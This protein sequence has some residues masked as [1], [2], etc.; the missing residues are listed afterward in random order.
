MFSWQRILTKIKNTM[1]HR[2]I[3]EK[4]FNV[5]LEDY[6]KSVL[7]TIVNSWDQMSPEE[8]TS[9]STLN[10]FFCGMH[11]LVGMA[12]TA[13]SSLLEW[14]TNYFEEG[15]RPAGPSVLAKKSKLGTV[16]LIRTACK[17][18]SKHGSEQ[19]G[20]YHP[21]MSYLATNGI[22]KNPLAT[23]R[24]NRF[25]ILFH[26]AAALYYLSRLIQRFSLEVWQTPNQLL[27]AVLSNIQVQEHLAGCR[28]QGLVNKVITGPL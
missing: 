20:V 14:E 8:Q 12:D 28:A 16:R 13:S 17:A 23:F 26:D 3:V 15:G 24:G 27:R 11:V 10:I 4:N 1:S 9:M 19:S 7:P 22:R 18:L 25:N 6:H 2:H 21:F 5:L